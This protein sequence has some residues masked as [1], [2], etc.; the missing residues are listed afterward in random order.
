[1]KNIGVF[2]D[3]DGTLYRNSLMVEHF[4]KLLKYEIIDPAIWHNIAKK[5]YYNWDKRRG[6]YIDYL[7]EVATIYLS[8]MKGLNKRDMEFISN[9]VIELKG[10]RVY[11]FT[12]DQIKWHQSQK[13]MI[14]FISGSPDYLVS[15]MAEKYNATDFKGTTF[16]VDDKDCFTGEIAKM[17]DS[18]NKHEAIM[19]FTETYNIDLEAS[20]AY[21]DTT[22]DF[23]MLKLV[24]NPIAINPARELLED[25]KA[26]KEL[27]EKTTIIIERKDVIYKVGAAVETI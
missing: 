8:S 23:A 17:W 15:K 14:F 26:D 20:Y 7:E 24:G 16:F 3:I 13:H 22:G 27:V 11:R 10:D 1:M 19:E 25:I 9:Q 6:N 12:R 18:E 4:K 5:T 21:G 2:I